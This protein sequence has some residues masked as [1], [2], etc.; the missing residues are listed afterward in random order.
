MRWAI[1]LLSNPAAASKTMCARCAKP[2]A[3]RRR[4]DNPSRS[5]RSTSLS[6]INTAGLPIYPPPSNTGA[7]NRTNYSI[8]TLALH[9]KQP[10]A[11]ARELQV[12][13]AAEDEPPRSH[14]DGHADPDV[15]AGVD[16]KSTRLNSSH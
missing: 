15:E 11:A 9:R 14:D 5:L 6:S 7:Y 12:G 16:R 3:V 1:A 8:R 4:R 10:R 13:F 2:W